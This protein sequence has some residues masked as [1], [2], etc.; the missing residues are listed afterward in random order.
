MKPTNAAAVFQVGNLDSAL[1]YYTEV[2][3]FSLD[4]RFGDYAGLK[5]G[6]VC[7]HL[8]G[9]SIHQRPVGAGSVYIFCDEV[10][11]YCAAIRA[12]GAR[13]LA[14][15]KAYAYGLRDFIT[16]D[17]DGN[18]LAFGCEAKGG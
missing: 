3:G 1:A 11:A 12:K 2:L 16:V 7:L 8:S 6:E 17:P 4:F 15:P 13:I 9:H 10:D 5:H 14:E 18:H